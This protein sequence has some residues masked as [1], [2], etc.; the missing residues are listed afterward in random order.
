MKR[1]WNQINEAVYSLVTQ[2]DSGDINMN[3]CTYVTPISM[4]PKQYVIGIYKG[5][6]TLVNATKSNIAVLQ[7]LHQDQAKLVNV[8]GKKSGLKYDKRAYL[9]RKKVLSIWQGIEVLQDCCAYL[10]LEKK[11][12]I[13]SGDHDVFIYEVVSFKHG[14]STVDYLN[15]RYLSEQKI[16]SI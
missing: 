13:Y 10:M 11:Q 15:T 2:N 3:I 7:F 4:K 12:Q 14:R 16:I 6:Q 5:T 9:E 1:P 8:L